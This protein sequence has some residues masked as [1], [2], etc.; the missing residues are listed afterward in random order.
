[1]DSSCSHIRGDGVSVPVYPDEATTMP[2]PHYPPALFNGNMVSGADEPNDGLHDLTASDLACISTSGT[3]RADAQLLW[4]ESCLEST[5]TRKRRRPQC[6][7]LVV[8]N[9]TPE[10]V[11]VVVS[12]SAVAAPAHARSSIPYALGTLHRPD[13]PL[14][15]SPNLSTRLGPAVQFVTLSATVPPRTRAQLCHAAPNADRA[16]GFVYK[17]S[18][19]GPHDSPDMWSGLVLGFPLDCSAVGRHRSSPSVGGAVLCTQGFGG[20]G[21]HRGPTAHHSADFECPVGT[22]LLA[23][24]AGTVAGLDDSRAVG[25]PH[26]DLL[27][28]AGFLR[29]VRADGAVTAVYLH[30]ARGSARVRAGDAV[31]EGQILARS[32]DTGFSRGPHLHFHV[33]RSSSVRLPTPTPHSG[34]CCAFRA[35]DC[36]AD[37]VSAAA[38]V[39]PPVAVAA[40]EWDDT[41][42]TCMWAFRDAARGAVIPVAGHW[43]GAS[44][45]VA[46][47][48]D[49]DLLR[50]ALGMVAASSTATAS[51]ASS[52]WPI[53]RA[54]E[55][56]RS[57]LL[58]CAAEP[59]PAVG[60]LPGPAAAAEE[61]ELLAYPSTHTCLVANVL[62]AMSL[63]LEGRTS[64][65][66]A[67]GAF[68]PV[69]LACSFNFDR[70]DRQGRG[71]LQTDA[72]LTRRRSS[73]SHAAF[74]C[75]STGELFSM[76]PAISEHQ[77]AARTEAAAFAEVSWAHGATGSDWLAF[78]RTTFALDERFELWEGGAFLENVAKRPKRLRQRV[79]CLPVWSLYK[80]SIESFGA[81]A[82]ATGAPAGVVA[83]FRTGP[84]DAEPFGV[85]LA[86]M[87]VGGHVLVADLQSSSVHGTLAEAIERLA[88]EEPARHGEVF[89]APLRTP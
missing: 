49:L 7:S 30:L 33:E 75:C 38:A 14:G 26:V 9:P 11:E 18:A 88:W 21:H 64:R 25:G 72:P 57:G 39:P 84:P 1:M 23:A 37:T 85:W 17:L 87:Q 12:M 22:P 89:F 29:L 65:F 58:W 8:E 28:E 48:D 20:K 44:G 68:P 52:P 63:L 83:V 79:E 24:F 15:A 56:I 61:D 42:P 36:V 34:D 32:G 41:A 74:P 3:V 73:P 54:R 55:T 62:A 82:C 51:L 27:P 86:W 40:L 2:K 5:P 31:A 46:P 66:V 19:G 59:F 16:P 67:R 70:D 80:T 50:E 13:L 6:L 77:E 45:W 4:T 60:V 53:E 81:A 10:N 43:Y 78:F 47:V 76:E 71:V 35:A 69:Y